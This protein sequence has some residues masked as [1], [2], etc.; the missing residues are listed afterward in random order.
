MFRIFVPFLRKRM[1]NRLI[2]RYGLILLFCLL[3][4]I[5]VYAAD[6]DLWIR[7]ERVDS[8]FHIGRMTEARAMAEELIPEVMQQEDIL[9]E[10]RLRLI[11]GVSMRS[12]GLEQDA[13]EQMKK[14]AALVESSK[15]ERL[16]SP[17]QRHFAAMLLAT[18]AMS[19]QEMGQTEEGMRHARLSIG[20]AQRTDDKVLQAF[21]FPYMGH[22]LLR[23][24]QAE[25][26]LPILQTGKRLAHQQGLA[27]YEK[28]AERD[29]A[30]VQAKVDEDS[31]TEELLAD[32]VHDVVS[33]SVM[34]QTVDTIEKEVVVT[35]PGKRQETA[36][37]R[38]RQVMLL[39]VLLTAIMLGLIGLYLFRQWHFK[40]K[41]S[42]LKE[43][44]ETR[45]L[46]GKEEERNRL[47]K[48]MHDGV[49][50]QLFAI[51]MK[52]QTDGVTPQT[53]QMLTESREQVRRVSH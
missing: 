16:D 2:D 23:C 28:I 5:E 43:D 7:V 9:S 14:A 22:V 21:I 48:E 24:G 45:Y 15:Y 44:S 50:N 25:E 41:I 12:E 10:A 20:W 4:G 1:R 38:H 29:I 32:K 40:R 6:R 3:C 13:L 8:L 46:E 47:A 27:E 39:G 34:D 51:E 35:V 33:D 11:I 31:Q 18:L 19:E 42:Q 49:S 30:E 17:V 37:W 52:L 26:A 53:M 36:W